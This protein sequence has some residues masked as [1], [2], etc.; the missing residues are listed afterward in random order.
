M[1]FEDFEQQL[2]EEGLLEIDI[3]SAQDIIDISPA[4]EEK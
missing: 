3:R 1:R 4:W 2:I